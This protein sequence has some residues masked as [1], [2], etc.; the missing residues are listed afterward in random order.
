M[1][2]PFKYVVW[3]ALFHTR[4]RI[5]RKVTLA[6][7]C[8]ALEKTN[9]KF[10]NFT[11]CSAPVWNRVRIGGTIYFIKYSCDVFVKNEKITVIYGVGFLFSSVE[12]NIVGIILSLSSLQM[13]SKGYLI[14]MFPENMRNSPLIVLSIWK[15]YIS[16]YWPHNLHWHNCH[17]KMEFPMCLSP[18]YHYRAPGKGKQGW[19]EGKASGCSLMS[20]APQSKNIDSYLHGL[21]KAAQSQ[22]EANTLPVCLIWRTR[23]TAGRSHIVPR[24]PAMPILQAHCASPAARSAGLWGSCWMRNTTVQRSATHEKTKLLR[25]KSALSV[26][27]AQ[28]WKCEC[29]AAMPHCRGV[30]SRAP[31]RGFPLEILTKTLESSW[32]MQAARS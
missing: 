12:L 29:A 11:T 18:G 14:I 23:S 32:T 3:D 16:T 7:E 30:V 9:F 27:M 8:I 28:C 6:Q 21:G 13:D 24:C 26:T 22:G 17:S 31:P 19:W 2:Y 20:P 4:S 5:S 1:C 10:L 25:A 15:H